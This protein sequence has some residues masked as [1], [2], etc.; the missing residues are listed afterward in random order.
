MEVAA[1]LRRGVRVI[2]VLVGKVELPKPEELPQDIVGL[3]DRQL[4]RISRE[5]FEADV[6]RLIAAV[7]REMPEKS[8][9]DWPWRT[10]AAALAVTAVAAGAYISMVKHEPSPVNLGVPEVVAPPVTK[11]KPTVIAQKKADDVAPPASASVPSQPLDKET[12]DATG[13]KQPGQRPKKKPAEL[14]HPSAA[15]APPDTL[16]GNST[17]SIN[18]SGQWQTPILTNPNNPYHKYVLSFEFTHEGETLFGNITHSPKG[19]VGR[20]ATTGILDGK[21]KGNLISF[22]TVEQLWWNDKLQPFKEMYSGILSKQKNE[23]E[24]QRFNETPGGGDVERFVANK[25]DSNR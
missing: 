1:A 2:P 12:V 4:V 24:F 7:A 13:E 23:I 14:A 16:K 15:K 22:H 3:L 18:V 5:R 6:L 21:I 19:T 25:N 11:S 10:V 9:R 20:T 17:S 8:W